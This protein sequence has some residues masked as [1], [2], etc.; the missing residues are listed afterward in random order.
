M[1]NLQELKGTYF[2]IKVNNN[3]DEI[4]KK[5]VKEGFKSNAEWNLKTRGWNI[6]NVNHVIVYENLSFEF[7]NHDGNSK[8][9]LEL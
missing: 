8:E 7:H 9:I 6:G 2:A 4:E 3:L 1:K 5:L